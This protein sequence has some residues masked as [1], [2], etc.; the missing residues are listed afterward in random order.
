[1]VN[2]ESDQ[3]T[4]NMVMV[5]GWD[6]LA[7]QIVPGLYPLS[8]QP[9]KS[10]KLKMMLLWEKELYLSSILELTISIKLIVPKDNLE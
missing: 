4:V 5:S 6:S 10:V 7:N 8:F 9:G 2:G 1:M 3:Q